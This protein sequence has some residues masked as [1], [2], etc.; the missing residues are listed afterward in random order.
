MAHKVTKKKGK[1][2]E[3]RTRGGWERQTKGRRRR[4]PSTWWLGVPVQVPIPGLSFLLGDRGTRVHTLQRLPG[5]EIVKRLAQHATTYKRTTS[6]RYHAYSWRPHFFR[7][8]HQ[9]C[10]EGEGKGEGDGAQ[11]CPKRGDEDT[12][13]ASPQQVFH[14]Q[15]V[16]PLHHTFSLQ[17]TVLLITCFAVRSADLT[18]EGQS[19]I[20]L[21][22]QKQRTFRPQ[23]PGLENYL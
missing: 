20:C 9:K 1:K 15:P 17:L 5:P 6:A 14:W 3:R 18:S 10:Q 19:C 2:R 13:L 8:F 11:V 22:D 23:T 4:G 16:R 12:G 7:V 21:N